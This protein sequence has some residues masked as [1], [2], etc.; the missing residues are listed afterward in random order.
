MLF[1]QPRLSMCFVNQ[2]AFSELDFDH[3]VAEA[4]SFPTVCVCVCVCVSVT[5]CV[6]LSSCLS[7]CL[8]VCLFVLDSHSAGLSALLFVCLFVRLSF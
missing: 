8:S 3:R 2:V 7:A 5:V 4:V 6:C 1:L